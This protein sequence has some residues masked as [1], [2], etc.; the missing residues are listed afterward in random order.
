MESYSSPLLLL[1]MDKGERIAKVMARAGLCSRRDAEVWI[2]EGRVKVDGKMLESPAF[3]VTPQSRI[4]VDGNALPQAETARLW[5]YYKPKGL[6]TTHKDEKG[7][8]T[9]FE[10][11]PKE[12]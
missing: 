12:L 8:F 7:R 10:S 1:P 5:R 4:L 3:C 2:Q 11:L 6:V 9:I